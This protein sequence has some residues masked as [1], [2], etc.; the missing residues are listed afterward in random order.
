[1]RYW[2]VDDP[3]IKEWRDKLQE[4]NGELRVVYDHP[5]FWKCKASNVAKPE[6]K[7]ASTEPYIT[8]CGENCDQMVSNFGDT[9]YKK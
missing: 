2:N 9:T 5:W 8:T 7:R 4:P 3:K 6:K 1:M